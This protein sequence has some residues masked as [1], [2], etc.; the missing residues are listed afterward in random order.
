MN[1]TVILVLS[2]AFALLL[3]LLTCLCLHSTLHRRWKWFLI[4][5]VGV[6]YFGGYQLLRD[7][8]GWAVADTTPPKF[9]FLA[10]VIEEPVKDKTKG[11]IFVW[12]QPLQ[13]NR[14]SGEPRAYRLP[15]EKGLHS[16]FEEANK[17]TRRGN[18]QMGSTEPRVGGKGFTWLKPSAN[19][20]VQIRL[21]DLPASQL[22]EK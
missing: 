18:A 8:Q 17:K 3:F 10:V 14:P 13:D 1:A 16:L 5:L 2:L 21:R 7:T 22:P 6:S 12:L 19:D 4:V 20:T 11:E 9:I 15:Y